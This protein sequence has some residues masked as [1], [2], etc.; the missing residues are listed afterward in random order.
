VLGVTI[1][2]ALVTGAN[3]FIGRNLCRSLSAH[4]MQIV[5]GVRRP[6]DLPFPPDVKV[7]LLELSTA[8]ARWQAALRSVECVI[9]LA[10]RAHKL[11]P[12][13]I[14]ALNAVNVEGA[15]FVAEQAAAG[16]ARRFVL[17]SSIKVNG[18]GKSDVRYR[19]DD[20]PMPEDAYGRSKLEAERAVRDICERNGVEFVVVR[21]PLVYGPGVKANFRRLMKMID[22]RIPL[23]F[24]SISNK[25]SLVGINNLLSF[26]ET[27][28]VHANAA[29]KVWLVSDGEDLSTPDL[30]TR[31]ARLM[32]RRAAL[33]PFPDNGLRF[34]GHL[35]GKKDEIERL[36]G[37]LQVDMD[38]AL[39]DLNWR[40][41]VSVDEGLAE[42]VAA[43]KME[44]QQLLRL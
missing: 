32:P 3:G 9:H 43:F 25:R 34:L 31:L 28:V 10:G 8:P 2:N 4:G 39:T 17:L 38:P 1:K 18:E 37:S 16:G 21:P 11:G 20:C 42:T 7:E 36:I 27:C 14:G 12:A 40:P 23:P 44:H 24:A 22:L 26:I 29:G 15:R 6:P 13:D 41:G 33:F 30:V 19:A 5:A 35:I